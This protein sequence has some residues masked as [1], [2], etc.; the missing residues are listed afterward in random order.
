MTR[1]IS[2]R[3]GARVLPVLFL[4]ALC[5]CG[6][7]TAIEGGGLA[8]SGGVAG[9][10]GA[11]TDGEGTGSK[12]AHG[13]LGAAGAGGIGG[14][15]GSGTS[16]SSG[17]SAACDHYF[18]AQHY[19][20]GGPA[21]PAAEI[22]RIRSRFQQVCANEFALPGSGITEA[23]L[24]SCASA[25]AAS[26]CQLPAGPPIACNFHGTLS[27]GAACTDNVQCASGQCQ[28]T[29]TFSPEGPMAPVTCGTCAPAVAVGQVC[30]QG[31]VSAGCPQ[32]AVCITAD[33]MAADP[34]YSCVATTQGDLGATCDDLSALCKVGLYCSAGTCALLG[35]A[36]AA[37][38]DGGTGS[39]DPGGCEAPLGCG[40]PPSTCHSGSAGASCVMDQECAAGFGCVPTAPCASMGQ[41]VRIGCS[42][43]GQCAAITWAAA[44]QPCSDLVQCLVGTCDFG[45]G[46]FPVSQAS[47]GSLV[48][49]TCPTVVPDGQ[50]CTVASTCDT[51]AQ[52]FQGA[53]ALLDGVACN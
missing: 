34:T 29:Q 20:C 47:D 46:F 22:S 50:P 49:G 19:R 39:G 32:A 6:S 15:V 40:D 36:G 51:F 21:L 12:T 52:C 10:G 18:D 24:E 7:G 25:L 5:D 44:G 33:T 9:A 11:N 41:V 8:D 2:V 42:T 13:S 17:G 1:W 3:T 53:C 28:G 26:P 37:C 43:S 45:N 38:G 35:G 27:G 4:A 23:S 16:T 48:Q 14:G 30:A 31:G